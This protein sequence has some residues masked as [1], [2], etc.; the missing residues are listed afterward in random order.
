VSIRPRYSRLLL[1]AVG[2]PVAFLLAPLVRLSS[3]RVGLAFVYHAVGQSTGD[4]GRE[5]IAPHGKALFE[6]Q[7]RHL[8]RSYQVVPASELLAAVAAR[9]RGQRIPVSITFDDDLASH[10]RLAIPVLT[11]VGAPATFFLCGGSLDRPFAY[12]WERLQAAHDRGRV[13]A[14]VLAHAGVEEKD[15]WPQ[16]I[17]IE[18]LEAEARDRLAESLREGVGPDPPDAGMR[19]DD[20]RTLADAGFEVG[21]HTLRH[22]CLLQLGDAALRIALRDGR[23]QLESVVGRPLTA[24]AYPH[25]KADKRVAAAAHEEG[26]QVGFT[27]RIRPVDAHDDPLL[28][29]RMKPSFASAGHFAVQ[30]LSALLRDRGRQGA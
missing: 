26:F 9:K 7:V 27:T 12:W 16:A 22:D 30:A 28:I 23:E 29:P 17:A 8:K 3:R 10:R 6:A 24:I 14:Q 11:G 2:R 25:G 20:V 5:L 21:F 18:G 13:P 4:P 1:R 19:S 15:I